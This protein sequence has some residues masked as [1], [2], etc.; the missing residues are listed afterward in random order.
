MLTNS[1]KKYRLSQPTPTVYK[2]LDFF[3]FLN[4]QITAFVTS[5]HKIHVLFFIH[6]ETWILYRGNDHGVSKV[7]L[8]AY[9]NY[10][11]MEFSTRNSSTDIDDGDRHIKLIAFAGKE[12]TNVSNVSYYVEWFL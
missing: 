7:V 10:G 1:V 12:D 11:E 2:K 6:L 3:S 8:D 9:E 4:A 5:Y